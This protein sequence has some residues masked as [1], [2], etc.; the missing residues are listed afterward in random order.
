MIN[1]VVVD[2]HPLVHQGVEKVVQKTNDIKVIGD[3]S[4]WEELVSVL[5]NGLPNGVIL[6]IS[7][8]GK[9]G[10]DILKDL[11]ELYPRLPV[12]I[13]SMHSE[14]RFA[15]RA[16]RAGAMG[17][18]NKSSITDQLVEAI[19]QITTE[20]KK[21]ISPKTAELLTDETD[22]T[23][24]TRENPHKLLSDREFQIMCEIASGKDIHR[25]AEEFSLSTQTIYTYRSRIKEKL[26]LN[27]NVEITRYA[28]ENNLIE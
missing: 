25:I 9:N 11:S 17:Y 23:S 6:D 8:P 1:I 12:L 2:D 14:E 4:N 13:L 15:L 16:L 7:L 24:N 18:L 27:S 21:Y 3:A 28:I 5:E 20:Q 10:L 26:N 22:S 19:R